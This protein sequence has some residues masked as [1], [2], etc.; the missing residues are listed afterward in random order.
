M[1]GL[2][3]SK[4]TRFRPKYLLLEKTTACTPRWRAQSATK[5]G[6]K[7]S[8]FQGEVAFGRRERRLLTKPAART[9]RVSISEGSDSVRSSTLGKF[10]TL[11]CCTQATTSRFVS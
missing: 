1:L 5:R 4:T 2:F 7:Y 6:T 8:G 10:L 9:E 11:N 3:A